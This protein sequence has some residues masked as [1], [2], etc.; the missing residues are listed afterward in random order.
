M[1]NNNSSTSASNFSRRIQPNRKAK[2]NPMM[3]NADLKINDYNNNKH[4]N[5]RSHVFGL[6]DNK[7]CGTNYDQCMPKSDFFEQML[8][9]YSEN[10]NNIY[11]LLNGD[12]SDYTNILSPAASSLSGSLTASPIMLNDLSCDIDKGMLSQS[13]SSYASPVANMANF[14]DFGNQRSMNAARTNNGNNGRNYCFNAR[15]SVKMTVPSNKRQVLEEEFRKEKY[16]SNEKLQKLSAK[17]NMRYDEVQ[18]YFKKRRKEEKETNHKFSN[19]V[20][21]LNNYLEE[22]EC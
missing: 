19:L 3:P 8:S 5:M 22:D 1:N 2:N 4:D 20:K 9:P 7:S 21:L 16:P 18:N 11:S 12:S 10:Q 13:N 17:L 6:Q 15:K 14:N